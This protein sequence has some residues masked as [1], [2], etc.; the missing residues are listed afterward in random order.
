MS[1]DTA[2]VT[3]T[4]LA[5]ATELTTS[6]ILAVIGNDVSD[7]INGTPIGKGMLTNIIN[8]RFQKNLNIN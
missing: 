7:S 1:L 4:A 6:V 8:A 5:N 2:K 3:Q